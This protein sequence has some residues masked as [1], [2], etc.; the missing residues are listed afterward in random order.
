MPLFLMMKKRKVVYTTRF[1]KDIKRFKNDLKRRAK[2]VS[3]I[4]RLAKGA[5]IPAE[6][7]PHKLIGNYEGCME[8]HIEGDLLLIWI[9]QTNAYEE[10]IVLSRL[11]SH[12]DLF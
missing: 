5:D 10:L 3:V 6:M 12:S 1:K 11:G 9:E 7:H 4:D 8:L 2:I